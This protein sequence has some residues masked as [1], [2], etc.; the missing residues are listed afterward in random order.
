MCTLHKALSAQERP[1]PP[2]AE[3][4]SHPYLTALLVFFL[5]M[6]LKVSLLLA[7]CYLHA[8]MEEA[9]HEHCHYFQRHEE[10]QKKTLC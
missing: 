5:I 10:Y 7:F 9:P 6:A 8:S 3:E 2:R 1:K 4:S